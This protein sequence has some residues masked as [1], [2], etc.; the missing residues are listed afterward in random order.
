[1]QEVTTTWEEVE[2]EEEET[3]E[4]GSWIRNETTSTPTVCLP[5]PPR[6]RRDTSEIGPSWPPRI[7]LLKR[8]LLRRP[9]FCWLFDNSIMLAILTLMRSYKKPKKAIIIY[10]FLNLATFHRK[11]FKKRIVAPINFDNWKDIPVETSGTA[12][13]EPI[14]TF[15]DVGL[16]ESCRI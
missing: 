14:V 8:K 10:C 3:G 11:L 13:P 7:R 5:T 9:F 6:A 1:M 12:L 4:E 15:K 2:E 16:G